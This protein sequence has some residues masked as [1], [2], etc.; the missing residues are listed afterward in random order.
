MASGDEISPTL[1]EECQKAKDEGVTAP[2]GF[3][4]NLVTDIGRIDDG[5]F[6]QYSYDA[7]VKASECFGFDTSYIETTSEADYA[8]NIATSLSDKPNVLITNGFLIATDT[9]AAANANP[10]VEVH[11]YRPVPGERLPRRTTSACCSVRT[12]V[13][14]SPGS[15]PHR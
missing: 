3:K 9:L 4:V 2:D 15:W 14:T 5:T 7:M 11:R 6:N 1:D 12:R 8:T 10:D 13:A